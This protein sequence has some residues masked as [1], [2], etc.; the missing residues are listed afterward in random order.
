MSTGRFGVDNA[1]SM[2]KK[3]KKSNGTENLLEM[4]KIA[5]KKVRRRV[6][7]KAEEVVK[8]LDDVKRDLLDDYVV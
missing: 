3:Y 5:L 7:E 1:V 2:I 8:I 6:L 4:L